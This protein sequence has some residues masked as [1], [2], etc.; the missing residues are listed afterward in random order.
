MKFAYFKFPLSQ[1]SELF[2]TSIIKPI[3]PVIISCGLHSLKYAALIDSG[4]DFCIFDAE[5]GDYLGLDIRTGTREV[6]GGIQEKGGAEAFLHGVTIN[7]G[8]WNYKTVIGFSYDIARH[9]FGILG[10]RGF[11]DMFIVKFDFSKEEIE[12]KE[13]K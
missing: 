11:F 1:R 6:F 8:G 10:Q 3:I 9:G 5:I 13:R 2:G 4:A 12:L 7:I